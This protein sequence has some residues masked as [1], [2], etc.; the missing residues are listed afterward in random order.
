M[1]TAD[2]FKFRLYVAGEGPNSAEA[3]GNLTALCEEHLRERHEI[4]VVDV[5]KQRGRALEDGVVLTPLLVKLSPPPV[6]KI[7]GN[8]SPADSVLLAL[9]IP[10]SG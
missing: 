3:A 6:C 9:G 8:L 5:V 10:S 2:H 1:K 4:E 7:V